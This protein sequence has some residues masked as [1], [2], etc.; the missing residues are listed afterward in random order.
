MGAAGGGTA[1]RVGAM[2]AGIA[3]GFAAGLILVGMGNELSTRARDCDWPWPPVPRGSWA[4]R[5]AAE[6][7]DWRR[8]P[9]PGWPEPPECARIPG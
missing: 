8:P 4:R 1:R 6:G 9:P 5:Q 3:I 2:I 7:L